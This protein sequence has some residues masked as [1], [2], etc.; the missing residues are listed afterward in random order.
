M[1][2]ALLAVAGSAISFSRDGTLLAV[3]MKNG[4]F[5]VYGV[6]CTY[7]PR[8]DL[9]H[10]DS[11][12]SDEE[13]VRH[14]RNGR[15]GVPNFE[16]G[17]RSP[18]KR[19][20]YVTDFNRVLEYD[21]TAIRFSPDMKRLAIGCHDKNIYLFRADSSISHLK[22]VYVRQKVLKGHSSGVTHLDFNVN[23]KILMSNDAA[24]EILFW[25]TSNGR[26]ER[27][28]FSLRDEDW[29]TW[30][31]VLGWPIQGA[32]QTKRKTGTTRDTGE[33]T[34]ASFMLNHYR[35]DHNWLN[36]LKANNGQL[37]YSPKSPKMMM[38]VTK[39][40]DCCRSSMK[41][42]SLLVTGDDSYN[43][44]LF[45]F[46][47]VKGA[48]PRTY[49]GHAA[50]VRSVR[51][52]ANDTHIISVG[53][54]DNSVFVWRVVNP[55]EGLRKKRRRRERRQE[56][57]LA[58]QAKRDDIGTNDKSVKDAWEYLSGKKSTYTTRAD[59]EKQKER[60][61]DAARKALGSDNVL[62]DT[63]KEASTA[64][65]WALLEHGGETAK[66]RTKREEKVGKSVE[67]E[68]AE[69]WAKLNNDD[70]SMIGK[71]PPS[72]DDLRNKMKGKKESRREK[73]SRELQ[74]KTALAAKEYDKMVENNSSIF[75]LEN[76]EQGKVSSDQSQKYRGIDSNDTGKKS[77]LNTTSDGSPKD[78]VN[79]DSEAE[80]SKK[81]QEIAEENEA[82]VATEKDKE[83]KKPEAASKTVNKE[84]EK[85]EKEVEA[86]K[87]KA[88]E[89]KELEDAAKKIQAVIRGRKARQSYR[90]KYGDKPKTLENLQDVADDAADTDDT[91]CKATAQY[92]YDANGD[93]EL[94]FKEGDIID[95]TEM[96]DEDGWWHG[97]LNGKFGAFPYNYVYLTLENNG[98]E[99]MLTT[100]ENEVYGI[101]D[102]ELKGTY[103]RDTKTFSPVD[104]DGI[105]DE[106]AAV[107]WENSMLQ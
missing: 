27:D 65:Q 20:H 4:D 76:E 5:A 75:P 2:Y 45:R 15:N 61:L 23:G 16:W 72:N 67:D 42:K 107:I 44:N 63:P 8:L 18:R 19:P 71:M 39:L 88:E 74:E 10:A 37:P 94:S 95:V 34:K 84:K 85:D 52:S 53:G 96:D 43:V 51:F 59:E 77:E 81:A 58:Y 101:D 104:E 66:N 55:T 33:S 17:T 54:S 98:Q 80:V 38:D 56:A 30:T 6:E 9:R 3:G 12:L 7:P 50:A 60:A 83:N 11:V 99:Y 36:T 35:E 21:I 103:D 29:A 13:R 64:S 87:E 90:E 48:K 25:R 49:R 32:W 78:G 79:T 82:K 31:C 46:P 97:R 57:L 28:P 102:G 89:E 40:H 1:T 86:A 62:F 92:D 105:V 69:L 22:G 91:L 24:R 73:R 26:Q 93:D 100:E 14:P 41:S 70:E 68:I 106:D 47:A